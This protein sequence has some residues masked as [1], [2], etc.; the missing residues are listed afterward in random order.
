MNFIIDIFK[1]KRKN[2]VSLLMLLFSYSFSKDL[3][4]QVILDRRK[5][6]LKDFEG[7]KVIY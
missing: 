5:N 2:N 6:I 4:I 3:L 7:K 1:L